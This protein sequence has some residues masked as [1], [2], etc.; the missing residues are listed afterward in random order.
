M[1]EST[2]MAATASTEFGPKKT[3]VI[4]AIVAGC[5]AILLPKIFYP[6]LTA[7]LT[8]SI[9]HADGSGCCDVI[10]E[11]D[12]TAVDIM[13][14]LCL[15]IIRHHQVD[16]RIRDAL[17]ANK[18]NKLTLSSVSLCRDEVLAK[19][20]IDLSS[21]LAEKER[22]KK[23][24]KQVLEEI[25]SFNGSLCLKMQFGVPL[26]RLGTPHLIR[27]HILM[28]HSSVRQERQTPAHAGSYHPALRE[29]GRAIPSSH[30][31]P[32]I[33]DRPD[34]IAL[35]MKMRP[36][37]GGAGHVVAAPKGNGF[38]GL[39]MPLYTIGI[40]IFF[41]YT[42]TK[43]LRKSSD[44]EIIRSEYSTA[45]A[46]KE[47]Q[48]IVFNPKVFAAAVSA[49]NGTQYEQN[50]H[51]SAR[52]E[53]EQAPTIEELN[54]QAAGDIE[55]DQL[56]RRLVETEAAM[57]RIVVQM[58]NL[59]RSVMNC[60]TSSPEP[61]DPNICGE[62]QLDKK[63]EKEIYE[64]TPTVKVVNMEMTA[65]CEGGQRY[66]RPTTPTLLVSHSHQEEKEK[67]PPISI[68]LEG[69]LPPQCEL[70]VTDSKTQELLEEESMEVPVVLSGKMTLSLISLD[71]EFQ[72]EQETETSQYRTPKRSLNC[73][74][75]SNA[76]AKVNLS[77]T[78]IQ[79]LQQEYF[80]KKYDCRSNVEENEVRE[81]KELSIEDYL[82]QTKQ[83]KK[84]Q[85]I[86]KQSYMQNLSESFESD[87]ES[88]NTVNQ[89]YQ[90]KELE[91]CN[92]NQNCD[93]EGEENEKDDKK[94][95]E[96][97]KDRDG[98]QMNEEDEENGESEG[99]EDDEED[100]DDETNE[101]S[102]LSSDGDDNY[103]EEHRNIELKKPFNK[104]KTD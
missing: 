94:N 88:D 75:E 2:T 56:R 16:P 81:E 86:F 22:L 4:L 32:K 48:K 24:Y 35:P 23:S 41:L 63:Y 38:V 39:L 51:S 33:Q 12:I 76:E 54:E 99:D 74:A 67:S 72:D 61:K 68:Y 19:C 9:H 44:N 52:E 97:N 1:P 13:Q 62:D 58:S 45:N 37:M 14:E 57:E 6:M 80:D 40:V 50:I 103:E 100:Q 49:V 25:R 30:I 64:A 66:S 47:Y 83:I 10:F 31:M 77:N 42:L 15:N 92:K 95:Q 93:T 96:E 82:F 46:E 17:G 53:D 65:T 27:Y 79:V 87:E 18:F 3:M 102:L 71:Q 59:S 90:I 20:G 70:L 7:S 36:P 29:R 28:P 73:T 34:H 5:F 55:I 11:S 101:S 21:F 69:S 26:A 85:H 60:S 84:D 104:K 91:K 78:K 43:V 8:P 98:D 89:N